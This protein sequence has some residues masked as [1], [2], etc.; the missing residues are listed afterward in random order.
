[1]NWFA[2][3]DVVLFIIIFYPAA[4]EY[5]MWRLGNFALLEFEEVK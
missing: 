3:L 5:L 2:H 4:V 1:M